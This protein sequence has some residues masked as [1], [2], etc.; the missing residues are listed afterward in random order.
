MRESQCGVIRAKVV[1]RQNINV[2]RAWLPACVRAATILSVRGERVMTIR[3]V[4][5][6]ICSD[7]GEAYLSGEVTDRDQEQVARLEALDAEVSVARY[8]A[9]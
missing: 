4:R 9:G 7:C 6:E 2:Q 5:A 1:V 8:R 3:G